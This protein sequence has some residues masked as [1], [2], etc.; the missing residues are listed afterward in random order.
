MNNASQIKHSFNEGLLLAN[1]PAIASKTYESLKGHSKFRHIFDS[2]SHKIRKIK[3]SAK[4]VKFFHSSVDQSIEILLKDPLVSE[5]ITCRKGCSACCFTQVSVSKEEAELLADLIVKGHPID[6]NRLVTQRKAQNSS[7]DWYKLPYSMRKCVF[8]NEN[9]ECSIYEHRP[10]V[11]RTNY[12]VSHPSHC[13]TENGKENTIRLLKTKKADIFIAAFFKNSKDSGSL[14]F[15]LWKEILQRDEKKLPF[16]LKN[17][18]PP[19]LS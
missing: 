1:L 6:V 11:C 15:M 4:R 12:V 3:N 10:A 7:V 18:Q 13:S 19:E 14:P 9:N 17:I 2:F 16:T 8:L 5:S